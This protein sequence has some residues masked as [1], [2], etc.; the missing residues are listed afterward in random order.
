MVSRPQARYTL[1]ALSEGSLRTP[2][3]WKYAII[4]VLPGEW[5]PNRDGRQVQADQPAAVLYEW[6]PTGDLDVACRSAQAPHAATSALP[7]ASTPRH[8]QSVPDKKT[9]GGIRRGRR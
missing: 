1:A 7:A 9:P 5:Y 2:R 6:S 8:L 4:D 3:G